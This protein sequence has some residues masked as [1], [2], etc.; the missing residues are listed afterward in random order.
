MTPEERGEVLGNVLSMVIRAVGYVAVFCF[1][2]T[3]VYLMY[4]ILYTLYRMVF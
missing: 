4:T 3:L 1:A 2:A